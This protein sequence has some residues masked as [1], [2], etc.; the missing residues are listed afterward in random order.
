MG[1]R[2]HEQREFGYHAQRRV[3]AG[4][5]DGLLH[6]RPAEPGRGVG[7][8]EAEEVRLHRRALG[9]RPEAG[10][11][12]AE[13]LL[14]AAVVVVEPQAGL[15]G[16]PGVAV[17]E[18]SV[19][20]G[21]E[22]ALLDQQQRALREPHAVQTGV[23]R[24]RRTTEQERGR[25]AVFGA[26][27]RVAELDVSAGQF[28]T[29]PAEVVAERFRRTV[30]VPR[31]DPCPVACLPVGIDVGNDAER[32]PLQQ[33]AEAAALSAP[34]AHGEAFEH[35]RPQRLRPGRLVGV[36][37]CDE[38]HEA[39][40]VAQRDARDR[41]PLLALA[42]DLE[43]R[44]VRV[45]V[46]GRLEVFE[47]LCGGAV[48]QSGQVEVGQGHESTG[49]LAAANAVAHRVTQSTAPAMSAAD[50]PPSMSWSGRTSV[51]PDAVSRSI[52]RWAAVW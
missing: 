23:E 49:G 48:A 37:A 13:S 50:G 45:A 21:P 14:R 38:R 39:W 40:T 41:P 12:V 1:C 43:R 8:A 2:E 11:A 46:A 4:V 47:D 44:E 28:A 52:R 24:H 22:P 29:A 18:R 33:V 9:R 6:R 3:H 19:A 30:G 27:V 15:G 17:A 16:R 35:E 32:D 10:A 51:A 26:E 36:G 31:L 34:V 20:V 42:D 7:I 5:V 25:R